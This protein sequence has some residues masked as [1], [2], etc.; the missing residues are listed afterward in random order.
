M[1]TPAF[2]SIYLPRHNST[3]PGMY[4]TSEPDTE[5]YNFGACGN[6]THGSQLC[7]ACAHGPFFDDDE[8]TKRNCGNCTRDDDQCAECEGESEASKPS[9][10]IEKMPPPPSR[11]RKH[12]P[13]TD[14][15]GVL[16][17]VVPPP[18]FACCAP[19][20]GVVDVGHVVAVRRSDGKFK[21]AC[22]AKYQRIKSKHGKTDAVCVIV[23][24]ERS[25]CKFIKRANWGAMIRILT[26]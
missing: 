19:M 9:E 22:I 21:Y 24:K 1:A 6:Y 14:S 18:I 3:A 11:K 12:R 20:S 10:P 5:C 16:G 17:D 26:S 4:C 23:D 2:A 13:G 15:P 8:G 7:E 25:E